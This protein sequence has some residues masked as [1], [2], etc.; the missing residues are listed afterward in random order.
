ME[1]FKLFLCNIPTGD[2]I[3][4]KSLDDAPATL[5]FGIVVNDGKFD[6]K[7]SLVVNVFK[8]DGVAPVVTMKIGKK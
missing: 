2:L 7:A 1:P 3:I 8:D 6:T 5:T 4:K